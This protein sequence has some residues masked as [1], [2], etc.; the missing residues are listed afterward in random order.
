MA[1]ASH[2]GIKRRFSK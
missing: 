1:E 2:A